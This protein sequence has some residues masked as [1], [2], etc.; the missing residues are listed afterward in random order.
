MTAYTIIEITRKY[1]L[2]LSKIQIEVCRTGSKIIGSSARLRQ[3]DI[4]TA[5]QLMYGLMLNSGNDAGFVLAKH[6]GKFL[7]KKKGYTERD[8]ATIRSYQFNNHS[9]YVKYFLKEMNEIAVSL[10]MNNTHWDSPHGLGNKESLTTMTDMCKLSAKA[11]K[12]NFF[13]KLVNTRE[14]NCRA[15]TGR[16]YTWW[17]GNRLLGCDEIKG[18]KTGWTPAAGHC[19][20]TYYRK[21][22]HNFIV[23]AVKSKSMSH[24]YKENQKLIDWAIM[25]K[26]LL[27]KVQGHRSGATLKTSSDFQRSQPKRI[28]SGKNSKEISHRIKAM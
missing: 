19:L 18:L 5:E 28:N 21:N 1:N 12:Q 4:L 14:Y 20:A 8:Q 10:K 7:Y 11:M 25:R 3:G 16:Q 15:A 26:Q 23:I 17:N 6:F 9:S 24:L 13:Q 2:D 27:A 22:G